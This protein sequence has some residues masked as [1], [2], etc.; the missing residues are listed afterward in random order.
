M[1]FSLAITVTPDNILSEDIGPT[2]SVIV[3]IQFSTAGGALN[4]E[5]IEERSL[6]CLSG[7]AVIIHQIRYF[8]LSQPAPVNI[9]TLDTRLLLLNMESHCYYIYF[10]VLTRLQALP[11]TM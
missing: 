2:K 4:L 3:I 10:L 8:R 5:C 11:Y 6:L 1:D 7:V 9:T